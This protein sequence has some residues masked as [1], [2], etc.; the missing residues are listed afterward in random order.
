MKSSLSP[1]TKNIT[2]KCEHT[3]AYGPVSWVFVSHLRQFLERDYSFRTCLRMKNGERSQM[4]KNN[5]RGVMSI[6]TDHT[7]FEQEK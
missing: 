6:I 4:T 7:G 5:R 2:N 3:K 1:L